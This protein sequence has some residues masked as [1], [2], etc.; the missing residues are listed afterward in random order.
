MTL[1][2][3]D[4]DADFVDL[5]PER[6]DTMNAARIVGGVLLTSSLDDA[7]ALIQRYKLD[8]TPD[9]EVNLPGVG[10]VGGFRGSPGDNEVFFVLTSLN[11]P[12]TVLLL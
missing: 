5:I 4:P 9:G 8:G 2:I 12:V 10:S 6:Q 3:A 11:V 1:D 7:T